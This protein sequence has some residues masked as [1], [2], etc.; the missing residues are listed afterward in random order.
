M[1][2][3]YFLDLFKSKEAQYYHVARGGATY[4]LSYPL[5]CVRNTSCMT[6]WKVIVVTEAEEL[7]SLS[8]TVN[9][10]WTLLIFI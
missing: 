6:C 5:N 3:I 4:G 2:M 7:V 9:M 8:I 10:V 1:I